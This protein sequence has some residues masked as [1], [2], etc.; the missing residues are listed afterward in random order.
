[1]QIVIKDIININIMKI[2]AIILT[3]FI[4]IFSNFCGCTEN[5]VAGEGSIIFNDFEGG[6]YGII[7][8]NGEKYDPINLPKEFEIDGVRVKFKLNILENQSSIHMW[9]ILVEIIEIQKL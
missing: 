2:V 3:L 8:D 9:G 7:A 5:Y 1:M 4:F 6:F